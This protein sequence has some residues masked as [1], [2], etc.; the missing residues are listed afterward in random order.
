MTALGKKISLATG[1]VALAGVLVAAPAAA[2]TPTAEPTVTVAAGHTLAT[3]GSAATGAN[4][5]QSDPNILAPGTDTLLGA[6]GV[7]IRELNT[8]PFDDTY[9][10]QTNT[11][12]PDPIT[13]ADGP[14]TPQP[15]QRWVAA[16]RAMGDQMMVHVNYGST[17]TD[18]PGG[19]DIGPQEAA[20]WVRQA[21]VVDHDGIKYWIIGEE[22]WGNGGISG[23][24]GAFEPDHHADKSPTAYGQN[25]ARFAAAMKAVDPT[26]KIGVELA[27]FAGA[28]APGDSGAWN[29]QMLAAAGAATDF[30]DVHVYPVNDDTSDA[31]TLAWPHTDAGQTLDQLRAVVAA[32]SGGRSVPMVVGETNISASYD[33]GTQSVTTPSALFAADDVTSL[34]E[35]GAADVNWFDSHH[36]V[37]PD[38]AGAPD[39][40]TSSGYGTWAL[41]SDGSTSCGTAQAGNQVCEPPLNTPFPAY[42]GFQL[43]STLAAPGAR[44]VATS[45]AGSPIVT[46]AAVRRDGRLVVL[47]ENEDP[48]AAHTVALNYAGFAP[49]RVATARSYGPGDTR[50][51]VSISPTGTVHL[52]PYTM[53]ELVIAPR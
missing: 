27:P 51:T 9:R 41:L 1:G 49:A 13:A 30:V 32:H 8:G 11:Y 2:S 26:I 42:Y 16:S 45:G 39:D 53:T 24:G 48:T 47:L 52:P 10:W 43:A 7:R 5:W 3:V 29:D 6:A 46:H 33:L 18:G 17:A 50:P 14:A 23:V 36:P 15:W 34:L 40:P 31:T 12:D 28:D 20:A 37:V 21:N 4:D 35:H 25:V 38:T 19:T 44:L 22:V